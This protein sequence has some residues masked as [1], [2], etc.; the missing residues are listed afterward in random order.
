MLEVCFQYCNELKRHRNLFGTGS[1]VKKKIFFKNFLFQLQRLCSNILSLHRDTVPDKLNSSKIY[2][3]LHHFSFIFPCILFHGQLNRENALALRLPRHCK[4]W[5]DLWN[6]MNT[7]K[8]KTP[9][10]NTHLQNPSS[11]SHLDERRIS[12]T[13]TWIVQTI[14]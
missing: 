7:S 14:N 10:S 11:I 4:Q 13:M 1:F 8:H 2:K 9:Y 12:L 3:H 5:L 6:V